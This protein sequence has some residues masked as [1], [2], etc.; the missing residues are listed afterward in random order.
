VFPFQLDVSRPVAGF[1]MI[2]CFPSR[3]QNW[4]RAASSIGS[5]IIR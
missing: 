4:R 3:Q 2:G 1:F 5:S